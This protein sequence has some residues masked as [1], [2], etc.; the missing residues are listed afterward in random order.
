MSGLG[1]R[2]AAILVHL[3]VGVGAV[4][5]LH[6]KLRKLVSLNP[7]RVQPSV[8]AVFLVG[9]RTGVGFHAVK[10]SPMRR[11]E[12]PNGQDLHLRLLADAGSNRWRRS[13]RF[14]TLGKCSVATFGGR[15]SPTLAPTLNCFGDKHAA[16]DLENAERQNKV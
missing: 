8:D 14:G 6:G 5:G 1:Y 2:V 13:V 4:G 11:W 12:D 9:L 10:T 15:T 7:Q 16:I 3:D